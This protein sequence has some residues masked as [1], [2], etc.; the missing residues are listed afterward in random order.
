MIPACRDEINL[1]PG[2]LYCAAC[3]GNVVPPQDFELERW[4]QIRAARV[5]LLWKDFK[6]AYDTELRA[7]ADPAS[8][9]RLTRRAIF[10]LRVRYLDK[11]SLHG[12]LEWLRNLTRCSCPVLS[13]SATHDDGRVCIFRQLSEKVWDTKWAKQQ[14]KNLREQ[15]VESADICSLSFSINQVRAE[16]AILKT[17][18]K[19]R[20]QLNATRRMSDDE[21]RARARDI[22]SSLKAAEGNG[23]PRWTT[24]ICMAVGWARARTCTF[25]AYPEYI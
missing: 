12:R 8:Q 17:D 13:A 2:E 25:G 11:V 9:R 6:E 10:F 21:L 22:D 19:D 18:I 15:L 14:A 1:Y 7:D 3:A 24:A 5:V 20:E 16:L 4:E 23:A